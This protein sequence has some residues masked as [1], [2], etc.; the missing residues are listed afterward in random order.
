V[1]NFWM[2][3]DARTSI[4]GL[5]RRGYLYQAHIERTIPNGASASA[6]MLTGSVGT[7]IHLI[8]S[9]TTA[10][11]VRFRL[12]EATATSG[13]GGDVT[14]VNLNQLVAGSASVSA[15]VMSASVTSASVSRLLEQGIV[16]GGAKGGGAGGHGELRVL[17]PSTKYLLTMDNL[18]SQTTICSVQALWSEG[19]PE[20]YPPLG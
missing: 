20:P 3:R 16:P 8:E 1:T 14:G 9:V 19:E 11:S 17:K 5:S 12:W 15:L 4:D 10:A 13:A 2:K 18:D 7:V 6:Q